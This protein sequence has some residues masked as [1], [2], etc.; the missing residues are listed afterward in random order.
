MD[1]FFTSLDEDTAGFVDIVDF[2]D[3]SSGAVVSDKRGLFELEVP[4]YR[5]KV[6]KTTQNLK[7]SQLNVDLII[8]NI[9]GRTQ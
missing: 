3:D 1:D 2:V 6:V 8:N 7:I 5:I 9:A 4:R